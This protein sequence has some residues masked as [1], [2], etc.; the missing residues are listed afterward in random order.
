MFDEAVLL[1]L[2]EATNQRNY[3]SKQTHAKYWLS[4]FYGREIDTIRGEEITEHLPIYHKI[5]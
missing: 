2:K 1:F 4:C 5:K 3:E